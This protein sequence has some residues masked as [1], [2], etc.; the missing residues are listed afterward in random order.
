MKAIDSVYTNF[1]G[2]EKPK[3][4]DMELALME[5]G[6]SLQH[7]TKFSFL[8][9]IKETA[10]DPLG[11]M[12]AQK[13]LAP[14]PA[15]P[16]G[17]SDIDQAKLDQIMQRIAA[18]EQ[19]QPDPP[20]P[21]VQATPTVPATI[22][23]T[24]KAIKAKPE[25]GAKPKAYVPVTKSPFELVLRKAALGAKMAGAEL[26]AFMGQ[27]AHESA[28]FTTTKEFSSG[29]QYEG[30]ADLGN[31]QPGDGAR[32]K[33]RGFIQITGRANYTAAGKA[34]GIDLVNYPELAERPDIAT[35]V[36][37]WYWN[38][39]VKPRVANFGNTKAVTKK[40]NGGVN[41]LQ[42]RTKLTKS[43]QVANK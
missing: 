39:R 40:V 32:Y 22:P 34:L 30:R 38:T 15:V 31:T 16:T 29:T 19:P 35:K 25:Q 3:F 12:L 6:H 10:G 28:K 33:G 13:G 20:A 11:A 5:G 27:C 21:A 4:T 24:K 1:W 18:A 36:S 8:K 9:L 14:P 43:F 42:D 41:G 23:T 17:P 26:A 7:D 37:I 2:R